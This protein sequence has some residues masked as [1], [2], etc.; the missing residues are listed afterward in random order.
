ME[1]K[2]EQLIPAPQQAVWDAL[3]DPGVL[4]ACVPGCESIEKSGD[5]EYQVLMVARVG[6]VSAKF[7]GRLTLSDINPPSSYSISFEG[8]GGAAGFAKGS[9]QVRLS[10][11]GAHT[12][13]AY[14]V[15]ANVGGK[16]AQIG[17]RLVDA[18]A[19]KVADD[20]FR[21]FNAKAASLQHPEDEAGDPDLPGVS[22]TTLRFLAAGA[23]LV[24]GVVMYF[25]L[26]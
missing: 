26:T 21:N 12:R 25:F 15:K 16:L 1:M 10:A 22:D 19:K 13:L 18:A 4:K 24:F 17:S 3:N 11:E 5:N 6:P 14:E 20:F 2:G 9:A 8:Q 23:L 7:K